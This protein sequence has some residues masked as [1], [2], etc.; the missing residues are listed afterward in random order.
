MEECQQREEISKAAY[1]RHH[2]EARQSGGETMKSYCQRH[3][4]S[5]NQFKYWQYKLFP[6]SMFP[7]DLLSDALQTTEPTKPTEAAI[8][9]ELS[10]E[11]VEVRSPLTSESALGSFSGVVLSIGQI[12]IQLQQGFCQQ[13][14]REVVTC[15]E[16][17]SC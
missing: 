15:L 10:F 13:T 8:C 17:W 2:L 14:L 7:S 16:D 3:G 1:W 5:Y 6:K 4:L 12:T 9:H 11:K